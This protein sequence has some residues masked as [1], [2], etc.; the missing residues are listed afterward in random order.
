LQALLVWLAGEL[1]AISLA[2]IDCRL[3]KEEPRI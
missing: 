2:I 3:P 1:R